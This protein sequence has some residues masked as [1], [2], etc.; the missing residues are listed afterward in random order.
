MANLSI[1]A[2]LFI[3]SV[4]PGSS[5]PAHVIIT[6]AI[7][8]PPAPINFCIIELTVPSNPSSLLPVALSTSSTISI[9]I[10]V[11]KINPK[12]PIDTSAHL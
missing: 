12:E 4:T 2:P 1:N 5:K 6:P 11:I 9:A 8:T 7:N 3:S 10:E